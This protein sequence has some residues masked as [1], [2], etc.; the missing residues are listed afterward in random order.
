LEKE[1]AQ[2]LY[3]NSSPNKPMEL[4]QQYLLSIKADIELYNEVLAK[5]ANVTP[6]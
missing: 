2:E 4:A 1:I 6:P 3:K 5:K